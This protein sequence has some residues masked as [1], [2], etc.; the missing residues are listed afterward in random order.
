MLESRFDRSDVLDGL[1]TLPDSV[2]DLVIADPPYGISKDFGLPDSY[3][4]IQQWKTWCEQWLAECQRVLKPSGSIIVYG[5]HHYLCYNQVQ[6][7]DLGMSYRR[8]IIWHYDNGFCGN[9][10]MRATYEP[11]LWF[12][13]TESFY[14]EEIRE[15]YKS[16]DRL[17]YA[18]NK[19]GK[20]WQPNPDGRL[21]GDVWSIPTLAGRRF[22][23]ERVKHPTQKPL[24]LCERLVKHFCPRGGLVLVPFGGSGSECVA[25]QTLGRRFVAFE[26]NADY[27]KIA[28]DR[29]VE[30]GWDRMHGS[31]GS[32]VEN[33][34]LV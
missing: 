17:K 11:M 34:Q 20:T 4:N 7:Y 23:D 32:A 24:V 19:N 9:R 6:L 27:C 16:A 14:F 26:I 15:P 22:A 30:A 2:A 31:A 8:Q 3:D 21:A 10:R 29:L 25:A 18:I 13:K 12:S 28:T 1:R 33:L 5:I